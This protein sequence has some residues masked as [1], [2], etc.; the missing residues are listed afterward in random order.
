MRKRKVI[1][2]ILLGV[3][4]AGLSLL[5]YPSVSSYWNSITQSRAI[6]DYD[7]IVKSLSPKDNTAYF[8]RAEEYNS[9]LKALSFPLTEYQQISGYDDCLNAVG[10]GV[11]GYIDI[12]KIQVKLPIYHGTDPSMLNH[13]CGHIQGSSFPIAGKGTHAAISAHRGLPSAKLFS[14]LDKL[15]VG[16]TFRITVLDKTFIYEVDQIKTV[17]PDDVSDLLIDE[18]KEL[19]I[20]VTCTPYGI[21]THRLLVRGHRIESEDMR[22]FGAIS[23]AF[24]IDRLIV[25]PVVAMPI[26][27]LLILY[28]CFKPA[29][30]KLPINDE[31][32]LIWKKISYRIA[33]FILIAALLLSGT[34]T[35]HAAS[36]TEASEKV[37]LRSDCTLDVTYSSEGMVFAG[38]D[39]KLW[40]IADITEDA[41]YALAGSFRSYPIQVTG[42]SSQSEWD[43][44]TITLN[45]YI[46]ADGIAADQTAKTDARGKVVFDNLTAGIY[47][48]SSVRTEQDGKYYVFESFL[49]AVPGVDSEGQWVYSVSARPKMSVHTPAKGEV[50]YKAVK[51]WRDGG[52]DRPV[53]VSVE[54]R[55]DGQ[56]Q[57]SVT[58]SAEN[59]WMYTWK[60]VDDG[61]VWTVNEV[62]V[63][64][65]YTV[66]IQRSGDTFSI[67]N[68]KPE[69]PD[70][71]SSADR[72]HNKL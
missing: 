54:V 1:T 11:I 39:I 20:L 21:N 65:G 14:D 32:E 25:T 19:C 26:I 67:T 40:H 68:T 10:D 29:K 51:A 37:Q 7:T 33:N 24:I 71:K 34:V 59:N 31:G 72:R 43:E 4:L 46:L 41:Q 47:L 52:Q 36:T 45:S 18:E 70:R 35:A 64:E 66:G 22:S 44:M 16:D 49:A 5:L 69:T 55:R 61:S 23:D 53:S 58:L 42:T 57:Q 56:L 60:A 6:V 48:V 30:R 13:A 63:P 50:T 9:E 27:L 3:F 62:N 17:L 12:D 8:E 38:Q 2:L 28:V 15:E